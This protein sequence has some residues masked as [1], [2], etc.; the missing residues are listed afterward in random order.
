MALGEMADALVLS[1]S[2]VQPARLEAA[3]FEWRFPTLEPA[4]REALA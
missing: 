3:G 1:S 4:L 2:R